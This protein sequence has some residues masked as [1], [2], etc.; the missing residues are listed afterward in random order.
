MSQR[1]SPR[2]TSRS[3]VAIDQWL[4]SEFDATPGG[5]RQGEVV[6]SQRRDGP[7]GSRTPISWLQAK[8]LPVGRAAHVVLDKLGEKDSNPH[9][10]SQSHEIIKHCAPYET[11]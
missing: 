3:A 4:L 10:L 1:L 5:E 2:Q 6:G 7:P 9:F 8:R 11:S